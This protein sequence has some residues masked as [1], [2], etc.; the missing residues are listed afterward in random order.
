[1]GDNIINKLYTAIRIASNKNKFNNI[2]K[3]ANEILHEYDQRVIGNGKES[4]NHPIFNLIRL[5]GKDMQYKLMT[6]LIV[7]GN[8]PEV[9]ER[10]ILFDL[11]DERIGVG[12]KN[13]DLFKK[14]SFDK[15]IELRKEVV[16]PWPWNR[17]RLLSSMCNYGSEL[18]CEKWEEDCGNHSIELWLPLG[19]CWV[20]GGN[21]SITTGILQGEGSITPTVYDIS[22]YY[23]KVYCDGEYYRLNANKMK[24]SKVKNVEFA[25]IYEI[26]RLIKDKN[27]VFN[28]NNIE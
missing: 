25:A 6:E 27:I 8:E 20:R 19:I 16:L 2:M 22:D 28:P 17:E 13:F 1:M 10:K 26:G 5:L 23:K 12:V 15:K 18:F 7:K 9:D 11:F 4:S 21:H 14:V 3:F 24:L